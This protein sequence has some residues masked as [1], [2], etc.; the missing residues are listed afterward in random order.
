MRCPKCGSFLEE[1]K[2]KCFMCG[3]DANGDTGASQ[4]S[5]FNNGGGFS[6]G[7]GFSTGMNN[8]GANFNNNVDYMMKKDAYNNRMKDYHNVDISAKKGEK[9]DLIDIFTENKLLFQIIG[10]ILVVVIASLI[11]RYIY[12]L[13]TAPVET[14]P[15]IGDLYYEISDSFDLTSDSNDTKVYVRSGGK[16]ASCS[17]SITTGTNTS[18]N[19][20]SDYYNEV[21]K[22]LAPDTDKEGNI[23]DE[24]QVFK[25]Q[26][27]ELSIN[28]NVWYFMNVYY[29]TDI[30]QSNQFNLKKYVYYTSMNKGYFYDIEVAYHNPDDSVCSS[31]IDNFIKS[32]KF[33]E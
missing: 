15:I 27:S 23:I 21:Q 17:V 14:Q 18:G 2:T 16:G 10:V 8:T 3:F 25:T 19:H 22:K 30:N 29:R 13:K 1:G 28:N 33:I 11:G 26:D 5:N 7:N 32:L 4:T 24:T 31:G 9:K 20:V 6:T 12:K